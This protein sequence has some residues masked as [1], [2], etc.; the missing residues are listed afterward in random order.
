MTKEVAKGTSVSLAYVDIDAKRSAYTN[1][2]GRFM[3]RQAAVLTLTQT[4]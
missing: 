4:F 2:K 3:G 1:A